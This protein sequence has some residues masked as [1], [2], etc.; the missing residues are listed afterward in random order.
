MRV[1]HSTRIFSMF[2]IF[3]LAVI[4]TYFIWETKCIKNKSMRLC[5]F[6]KRG[7]TQYPQ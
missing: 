7:T 6:Q 5:N 4:F 2:K 1:H 3:K